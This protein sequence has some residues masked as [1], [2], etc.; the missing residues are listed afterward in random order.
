M[1]SGY[2]LA[3]VLISIGFCANTQGQ[4]SN[5]KIEGHI[6]GLDPTLKVYLINASQRKRIDSSVVMNSRFVLKGKVA[7]PLFTYLYSGKTNKMADILLDNR[8]IEVKGNQ[9]IYD[10]VKITGSEIDDQWRE[11]SD[12]DQK[13]GYQIFRL[14]KLYQS[15]HKKQ[16]TEAFPI[17]KQLTEEL[18]A[19]RIALLKYYVRKY[20][21]SASGAL[22]PTLCT[23]QDK[24]QHADYVEMYNTLT[25]QLQASQLGKDILTLAKQDH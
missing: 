20:H 25:P 8:D 22:L 4:Q 7:E 6:L 11:W 19:D 14:N 1:R 23:I 15:L 24:L 10:S 9:P 12:H 3:I 2:I 18:V 17:V 16:D 13:I 5:Y 21:N